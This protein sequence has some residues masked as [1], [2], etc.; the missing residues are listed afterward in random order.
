MTAND[1][2]D[3]TYEQKA[4]Y[5][6][7]VHA[8][9][10]KTQHVYCPLL[11]T[12]SL[13]P[14]TGILKQ[15]RYQVYRIGNATSCFRFVLKLLFPLTC[16]V[17][18]LSLQQIKHC[19]YSFLYITSLLIEMMANQNHLKTVSYCFSL[20]KYFPR[21]VRVLK[22]VYLLCNVINCLFCSRLLPKELLFIQHFHPQ[23]AV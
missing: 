17:K 11:D 12:T 18:H 19:F 15:N 13:R 14:T 20:T 5:C 23:V 2:Q 4:H 22:Y 1:S 7:I 6:P 9:S 3:L 8:H 10:T 21:T 16:A